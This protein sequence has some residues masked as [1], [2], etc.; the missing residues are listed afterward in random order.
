MCQFLRPLLVSARLIRCVASSSSRSTSLVHP[1]IHPV[2]IRMTHARVVYFCTLVCHWHQLD[3]WISCKW[4]GRLCVIETWLTNVFP[5]HVLTDNISFTYFSRV[6]VPNT[7]FARRKSFGFHGCEVKKTIFFAW[8]KWN[9]DKKIRCKGKK[10]DNPEN[11]S[12]DL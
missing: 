7:T 2:W 8:H 11:R 3:L 5:T 1:F 9:R 12:P 10:S 4:P 6:L